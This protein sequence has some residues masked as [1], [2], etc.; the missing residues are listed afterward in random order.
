MAFGLESDLSEREAAYVDMDI[1]PEN[2][3]PLAVFGAMLTQ[4][5]KGGLIYS[6]LPTV[7]RYLDIPRA[8][9]ASVFS[10]LQIL[11]IETIKTLRDKND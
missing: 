4:W 10:D 2:E 7:M 3:M 5:H 9:Q 6:A 11:E 8:E 1:W